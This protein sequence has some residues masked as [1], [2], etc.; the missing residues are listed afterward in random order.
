[1]SMTGP[2]SIRTETQGLGWSVSVFILLF[3]AYAAGTAPTPFTGDS[4]ELTAAALLLGIAH[5]PGYPLFGL[6]GNI[7]SVLM[8]VS[9]PAYRMNLFSGFVTALTWAI[10]LYATRKEKG[11]T[12]LFAGAAVL[13]GLSPLVYKL[14]ISCEVFSLNLLWGMVLVLLMEKRTPRRILLFMLL[15]GLG[16]GNHH[17]LLLLS[18]AVLL[19]M[20]LH[21][22]SRP[23][24]TKILWASLGLFLLGLSLYA[25]LP[26][27][28]LRNPLLDWENPDTWER[29]WNVVRR[30][31]Y[32]SLQLA[33]GAVA[34]RGIDTLVKQT[35]Y[36][37]DVVVRNI[38]WGG[39]SLCVI[40]LVQG[41]RQKTGTFSL[42]LAAVIAASGPFFLF[43]ANVTPSES[44][45]ELIERFILL[46][47]GICILP[48]FRGIAFLW[49]RAPAGLGRFGK[50]LALLLVLLS[51]GQVTAFPSAGHRS[52]FT[53]RDHA[54]D[55]LRTLPPQAVFFSDRADETEFGMLYYFAC[56]K[57]RPDVLFVDCNAGVTENIYGDDYYGVWGA[58]RL[59]RRE[60]VEGRLIES[61]TRPVRYA[62]LDVRQIRLPRV[63]RGLLYAVLDHGP[64]V[65]PAHPY[66]L[67]YV[68]RPDPSVKPGGREKHLMLSHDQLMG[69]YEVL[70]GQERR[71]SWH[72]SRAQRQGAS[73]WRLSLAV[74][75]H[76]SGRFREAEESY[77]AL[78]K[79]TPTEA[80]LW[81]NLGVL[82]AGQERFREAMVSYEE[83]V[84]V[85][86]T[87]AESYY[88]MGVIHWKEGDWAKVRASFEKTLELKPD[89]RAARESLARLQRRDI[90]RL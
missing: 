48:V 47:L 75:Y 19:A 4:S 89:H 32:G 15:W 16:L 77:K 17:T 56:A 57:K 37:I 35:G 60:K 14:A 81:N 49:N 31:R 27:R 58:P 66:G 26:V 12:P 41:L 44:S 53:V 55:L 43:W 71:A 28:S 45:H 36:F 8:P 7:F 18:P 65:S 74:Q 29:F 64:S 61:S 39:V 80:Y 54:T 25:Y 84:R 42:F 3:G 79:M 10:A 73:S 6:L 50:P 23:F 30:A 82:Y 21:H 69:E 38:G 24:S 52:Y 67:F 22:R 83:A 34:S 20:I 9:N 90:S 11:E 40:G 72:F 5:S 2:S 86:P 62:T 88:N 87:Y 46:P 76:R 70:L 13:I 33:Q 1:M 59:A 85:D 63:Q 78:L 51:I 68:W